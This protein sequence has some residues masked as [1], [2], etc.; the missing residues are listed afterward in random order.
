MEHLEASS[1]NTYTGHYYT[2]G[3][4]GPAYNLLHRPAPCFQIVT[5]GGWEARGARVCVEWRS[6]MRGESHCKR[7]LEKFSYGD[8]KI[9]L[10]VQRNCCRDGFEAQALADLGQEA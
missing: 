5:G 3:G 7:K 9:W 4:T 1:L 8:A 2:K 10:D 6:L